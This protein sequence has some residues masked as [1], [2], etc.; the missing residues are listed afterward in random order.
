MV[1]NQISNSPCP[2]RCAH[3]LSECT[4]KLRRASNFCIERV[5][6]QPQDWQFYE[7]PV[8]HSRCIWTECPISVRV[9]QKLR[10]RSCTSDHLRHSVALCKTTSAEH[11]S[12]KRGAIIKAVLS[13]SNVVYTLVI[14]RVSERCCLYVR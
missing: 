10:P 3:R 11:A 5:G 2:L 13:R 9:R 7:E 4:K 14:E 12:K 1:Y 8:G 6:V